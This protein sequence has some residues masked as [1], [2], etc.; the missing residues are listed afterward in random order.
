MKHV[1]FCEY[2]PFEAVLTNIFGTQNVI[3]AAIAQKVKKGSFY[4]F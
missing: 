2:N 1:S 3:K 4:K